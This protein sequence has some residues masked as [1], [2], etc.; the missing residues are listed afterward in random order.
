MI[1]H[2]NSKSDEA[3]WG[4]EKQLG[5]AF[6]LTGYSKGTFLEILGKHKIPIFRLS[7]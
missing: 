3:L 5:Q 4:R 2:N 1:R 6:A 7:C